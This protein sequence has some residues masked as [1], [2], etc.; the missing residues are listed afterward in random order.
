MSIQSR[1]SAED[2]ASVSLAYL[3]FLGE[4]GG[5]G[6]RAALFVTNCHGEPLEFCFTRVNLP[7]DS[8]WGIDAAYRR[9]AADLARA[10]F[11]E[12]RH[13]PDV[14]LVLSE[15]TPVDFSAEDLAAQFPVGL[16]AGEDDQQVHWLGP[17]PDAE[18]SL[19]GLVQLLAS[20]RRLPEPFARAALGLEEA[21]AH[22]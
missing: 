13:R 3:R 10:L 6:V 8:L 7:S 9:A 11:A 12:V 22:L 14:A 18:S 17:E 4:E 15:E 5:S 2:W 20:R 1:N 21:Y 19:A 16:V